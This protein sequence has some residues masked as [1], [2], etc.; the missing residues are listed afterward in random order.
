MPTKKPRVN[1]TLTQNQY[2]VFKSLSDSSGQAM[3]SLIVEIIELSMPTF[4]RMAATFQQLKKARDI[5]RARM[6]EAFEETQSVLEPLALSAV[7]QFDRFLGKID[8]AVAADC[9]RSEARTRAAA[10]A[11][12]APL[13]NRGV[14][15]TRGKRLQASSTKAL[16]GVSKKEV[17][18]KSAVSNDHKS[19]ACIC[20]LTGHERQENKDCPVHF[21][22]GR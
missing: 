19:G 7:G 2:N 20:T 17:L 21:P 18:K 10:A 4:E 5:D 6:A 8:E 16:K 14:T 15:P 9:A 3:S 22:K 1:I 11:A 12:S 13:T